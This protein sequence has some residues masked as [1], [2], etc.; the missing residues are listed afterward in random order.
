M[1]KREPVHS[2]FLFPRAVLFAHNLN[3]M[4]LMNKAEVRLIAVL[5]MTGQKSRLR[6]R[7]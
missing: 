2:L 4:A 7:S 3:G 1:G 5:I 6:D